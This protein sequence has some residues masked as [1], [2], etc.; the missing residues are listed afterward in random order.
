[1]L[2]TLK[3][4]RIFVYSLTFGLI[5]SLLASICNFD[6]HCSSI[7]ENVVRLHILANSNTVSD[8]NLKLKVRDEILKV[9]DNVFDNA[10]NF[11]EAKHSAEE[12]IEVFRQTAERVINE[13]GYNYS[14]N[15]YIGKSFFTTR[16]YENFTLPAGVYDAV[17][18]EIGEAEGKNWWCVMF[19][20]VCIPS[21]TG[22]EISD[23]LSESDTEIV[24]NSSKYRC[25]FKVIE[26]YE[27]VKLFFNDSINF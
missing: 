2:K 19:P 16:H 15:V 11:N 1:M 6:A 9:S 25:R 26:I 14:V 21:A 18:I 4:K 5:F 10:D 13:N 7:R 17:K 20:P 8:Q 12:N 27:K 23:T 3:N 24:E 22:N